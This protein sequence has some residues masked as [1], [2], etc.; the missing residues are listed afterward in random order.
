LHDARI[1]FG[2]RRLLP[3]IGR[4]ALLEILF[5]DQTLLE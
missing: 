3:V 2:D 1:R 4:F 5:G